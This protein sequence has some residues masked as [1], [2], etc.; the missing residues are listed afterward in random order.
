MMKIVPIDKINTSK[1]KVK[2]F[3]YTT[4]EENRKYAIPAT[5]VIVFTNGWV[6]FL[7][8]TKQGIMGFQQV[9]EK[10]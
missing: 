2:E 10:K 3:R 4:P 5:P 8:S 1:L 6:M 9:E 7:Q